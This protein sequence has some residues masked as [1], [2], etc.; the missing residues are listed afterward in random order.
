MVS[1]RCKMAMKSELEKLD[2]HLLVV[3]LSEVEVIEQLTA[4][5]ST[6]FH[7]VQKGNWFDSYFLLTHQGLET[8][9]TG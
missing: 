3:E 5:V 7:A 1:K 9:S 2:V 8:Q 4:E 6:T